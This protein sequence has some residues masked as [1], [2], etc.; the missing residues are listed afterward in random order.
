LHEKHDDPHEEIKMMGPNNSFFA[1]KNADGGLRGAVRGIDFGSFGLFSRV[2]TEMQDFF[3]IGAR[4]RQ[5][6]FTLRSRKHRHANARLVKT[7]YDM[8]LSPLIR[9]GKSLLAGTFATALPLLSYG[10]VGYIAGGGEY[11]IVGVLPGAQLHPH[12]SVNASGGY[13]VWE[14]NT[15]D[16]DGVGIRA[17]ALNNAFSIVGETFRVNVNARGDQEHARVTLLNGGG[18]V[19]VWQGGR[20]GF[21]HVYARFLSSSNTWLA[22][23][24]PVNDSNARY[25]LNPAITTLD[26]GNVAI[27]WCNVTGAFQDVYAQI[28]APTGQKIG[29]NFLVNQFTP[30]NQ[31]T[32][33]ISTTTSNHFIVVWVSEQEGPGRN[34]NPIDNP[35]PNFGYDPLSRP[36]VDIYGRI[37]QNDDPTS[38]TEFIINNSINVCANPSVAGA[39]DGSYVVA[40]SQK[41]YQS[42]H[43]NSWDVYARVY[44]P[45]SGPG[46][47]RAINTQLYGDQFAPQVSVV[48]ANYLVLWSSMGQDGSWEGV[49]GQSVSASDASRVGPEFRVNS[50]TLGK[51]I[52][53]VLVA[54][55]TGRFLSVWSSYSGGPRDFDLF[56]QVYV[57]TNFV[58]SAGSAYTPPPHEVFMDN[59]DADSQGSPVLTTPPQNSGSGSVSN[60]FGAT[61]GSYTGLFYESNG[62]ATAS[63][64]YF[65]AS[66]TSKGT[67][68]AKLTLAGRTY[69]VTGT[70]DNSGQ[71]NATIPRGM[72]SSLKVHLQLDLTG[73]NQIKGSVTDNHWVA[74]LLAD[75][76]STAKAGKATRTYVL[77]IP[78]STDGAS[79]PGGD[80]LGSVSINGAGSLSWSSSLA[81]GTKVTQ[82][83]TIS[84]RGMWP[85]YASLYGGQG[86]MVGWINVATNT[87]DG[88]LVWVKGAGATGS[89]AKSYSQGFTNRIQAAGMSYVKPAAGGGVLDWA[90]SAGEISFSSSSSPAWTNSIR[91]ELNNRVTDLNNNKL[92]LTIMSSSGL[93]S[94]SIMNPDTGKPMQFQGALYQDWKVGLGYFLDSSE[95]GKVLLNRAP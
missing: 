32:P 34:P 87:L 68:S 89:A 50:T 42:L 17:A 79:S 91:L 29:T 82:K 78:G 77:R 11:P 2:K 7:C 52:H 54:D 14:D 57:S 47:T 3:S 43:G 21:Q 12:A 93:F 65:I 37:F 35:D 56:A 10:Q 36:S 67:F 92:K 75:R 62:V 81:D 44:P 19:F 55:Q 64:G 22:G 71:A 74:E 83:T 70:F 51:Q 72:S 45:L 76:L 28:F 94:G 30:F 24:I 69:P 61:Q 63:A 27:V 16:G 59:G 33:A 38:G 4:I 6:F 49:Y 95:S 41:D 20:Q 26:N 86:C 88:G 25:Q 46:P 9:I 85:L 39:S 80:G 84:S 13:L 73:G 53:P 90:G 8:N 15:I 1:G 48:G 40:W 66:L 31:R 23:D 60:L 58:A 18:A 5:F